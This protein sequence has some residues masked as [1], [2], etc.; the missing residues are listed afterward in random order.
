MNIAEESRYMTAIQNCR[1]YRKTP[2]SSEKKETENNVI[3]SEIFK[4]SIAW[5]KQ[6]IN[7]LIL[8]KELLFKGNIHIRRQ[9]FLGIFDLPAYP[10]QI[11]YY[12]SLC[13]KIRCSLAYLHNVCFKKSW[14]NY[15]TVSLLWFV[16]VFLKQTLF[17]K[18]LNNHFI[19]VENSQIKADDL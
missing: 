7:K 6:T 5:I 9:I 1:G 4:G 8:H 17:Q 16:Q 15:S 18:S 19:Y 3:K 10:N 13:S 12:I 14:T 2:N 11:L